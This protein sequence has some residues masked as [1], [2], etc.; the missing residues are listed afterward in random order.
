MRE[1]RL[2]SRQSPNLNV[3]AETKLLGW[4]LE[5][6]FLCSLLGILIQLFGPHAP[7]ELAARVGDLYQRIGTAV[8]PVEPADRVTV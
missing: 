4:Y 3:L 5:L 2:S 8:Q 6:K 1:H 7:R